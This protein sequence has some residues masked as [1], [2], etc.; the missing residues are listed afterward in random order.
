MTKAILFYR[1]SLLTKL[2]MLVILL[3]GGGNSTWADIIDNGDGTLTQDFTGYNRSYSNNAYNI[4]TPTD[5]YAYPSSVPYSYNIP[6]TSSGNYHTSS[7]SIYTSAANNTSYYI[8]TPI[9]TGNFKLWA[10]K[11]GTSLTPSVSAY[12]CSYDATNGTFSCGDLI[13]AVTPGESFSEYVF[14]YPGD[15]TRVALLINN[16]YIDDFT[17]TPYVDEGGTPKPTGFTSSVTSYYSASLRWIAG[18]EESQWQIRWN[19]DSDFDPAKEEG[20]LI[21]YNIVTNPYSLTELSESST[22][23]AY[24]RAYIDADT[25]SEWTGPLSFTTY[26]QYPTPIGLI[27]SDYANT[28]TQATLS[29]INGAGTTANKWQIKYSTTSSFDPATEGT[30]VGDNPVTTNPYTINGLTAN[31]TY[32][33]SIRADYGSGNY[34][35]WTDKISF[36]PIEAWED[37]SDGIPSSWY[38]E[39]NQ[40]STSRSGY[41]GMASATSNSY[42]LRSPRI[43]MVKDETVSFDLTVTGNLNLR[44]FRDNRNSSATNYATYTESGRKTFIAP[45][46]GYY[47][48]QFKGS[49]CA[50]DNF[51]GIEPAATEHLLG[52]SISSMSTSGT[53]GGDFSAQVTVSELGGVDENFTV[54]LLYDNVV[55]AEKTDL[56]LSANRNVNVSLNFTPTEAKTSKQ[57]KFIIIY[58][59]GESNVET[60][61]RSVTMS[62]TT[63]ELDEDDSSKTPGSSSGMYSQVLKINYTAQNGWNT[64][65]VP[66][67]LTDEYLEQLFGANYK[68]YKL[69]S[70]SNGELTFESA[71]SFSVSTPYLVYAQD[72][73]GIDSDNILLKSITITSTNWTS[74]NREQTKNDATFQGTWSTKAYTDGDNWYGVTPSG[75]VM[76]AGSGASVKGYRAYLTGISAPTSGARISI[77]IDEGEGETTDLGFVK[78]VD[79]NAKD[80]YTLSG[81]KVQKGRKGIY[82]VNGRKVVIK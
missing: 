41:E 34:S 30:M 50:I 11:Y 69:K 79:E 32:Y 37:F 17:Y 20:T 16:S 80:I 82:I 76:K 73:S 53:V 61:W 52:A 19:K 44:Y 29:W 74:A 65:C 27:A 21:D 2:F 64:I 6:G 56:S 71:S 49:N 39:D 57:M 35:S 13:Q 1:N 45:Y 68:I 51:S 4:T 63:Y 7:P 42:E 62:N 72:V 15:Q 77:V 70:Y 10:K 43:Y 33:A 47:W 55:V 31:T 9:L 59:G 24:V 38:N 3:V 60:G 40:W 81:Q 48:L 46:T 54:Q 58:N 22:Y 12:K 23:Y 26:E 25:Q 66:F 28:G 67:M 36:T 8:I 5:W 14:E 78:L 75:R 18:G